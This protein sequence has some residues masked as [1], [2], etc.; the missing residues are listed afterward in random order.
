MKISGFAGYVFL[1]LITTQIGS[2]AAITLSINNSASTAR[3]IVL[4]DGVTMV[5]SGSARVGYF[6]DPVA[7]DLIMRGGDWAALNAAFIALGENSANP[8]AGDVT[9]PVVAGNL[10]IPIGNN[11]AGRLSGQITGVIGNTAANPNPPGFFA[12]NNTRVFVLV[13]N[14]P[15]PAT[16]APTQWA[17]VS[18][19]AWRIPADDLSIPGG[20]SVT[21]ALSAANLDSQA[22]DVWRGSFTT[23]AANQ[24]F[25]VLQVVPEPSASMLALGALLFPLNRRRR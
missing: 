18:E 10:P 24:N 16:T 23:P 5:T 20:A 25:L 9:T 13:S 8:N 14:S 21:L 4:A 17:L 15:D 2:D 3:Q 6:A 11:T 7:S 1:T 12:P 19:S 22:N